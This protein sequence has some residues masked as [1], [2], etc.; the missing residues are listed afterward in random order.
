METD[1]EVQQGVADQLKWEPYLHSSQLRVAVKRG[2]VTLSGKLDTLSKKRAAENAAGKVAG[3]KAVSNNIQIGASLVH[4]KS[5]A[6]IAEAARTFLKWNTILADEKIKVKVE[7]GHIK[8]EG[9]VRWQFQHVYAEELLENLNGVRSITNLTIIQPAALGAEIAQKVS[10]AFE[11]SSLVDSG[12]IN[13][14]VSG[15]S[16][17]LRGRARSFAEKN[18][19]EVI[20]WCVPGITGVKNKIEMDVP[21]FALDF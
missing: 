8:L 19:A 3:V 17:V 14:D 4:V 9:E 20:A 5:D 16:L 11:R 2:I 6:E 7:N 18:E 10:T 1:I 13:V 21:E 15:S 12:K